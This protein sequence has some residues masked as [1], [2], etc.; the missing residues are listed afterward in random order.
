MRA[1]LSLSFAMPSPGRVWIGASLTYGADMRGGL[2]ARAV[3]ARKLGA[4]L[5]ATND[6]L[7]HVPERRA[8]AD[9]AC[10]ASARRRRWR[11]RGG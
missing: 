11:R 9:V 10:A 1:D 2:A 3:L 7:M 4:P 6:V 8:L 5:I